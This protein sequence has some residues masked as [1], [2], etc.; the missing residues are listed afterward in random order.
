MYSFFKILPL[1]WR[2]RGKIKFCMN[3]DFNYDQFLYEKGKYIFPPLFVGSGIRIRD[4][5]RSDPDPGYKKMVG[6]GSG[7]NIPDLQ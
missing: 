3:Y 7:R 5:I 6:S 4:K 2:K 1:K